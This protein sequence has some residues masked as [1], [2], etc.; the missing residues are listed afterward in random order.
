MSTQFSPSP[1][2]LSALELASDFAF[3]LYQN[4]PACQAFIKD[5]GL[6]AVMGAETAAAL[7]DPLYSINEFDDLSQAL[8]Q[9]R[10]C[11]MLRL[12]W[13]DALEILT[14]EELTGALSS[15]ACAAVRLSSHFATQEIVS[16]YE[17][18]AG[19]LKLYTAAMGKMGG[20]ELNLSSDIDLVYL[21]PK[22]GELIGVS[23]KAH[24]IS[25]SAV[26]SLV[27]LRHKP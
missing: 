6:T 1:D 11:V 21:Y 27:H 26:R 7:C 12:I 2:Q 17:L 19:S 24:E 15:F 5:Q 9:T 14:L 18:P 20:G 13:Q 22:D 16:R 3:E 4:D 8:R 25:T 23:G 10:A